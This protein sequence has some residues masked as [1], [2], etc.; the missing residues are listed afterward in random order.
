MDQPQIVMTQFLDFTLKKTTKRVTKIRHSA[1]GVADRHFY[2][3]SD[4]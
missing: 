4:A 3:P 2:L 1:L